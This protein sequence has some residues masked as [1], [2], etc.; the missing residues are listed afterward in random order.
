MVLCETK[1]HEICTLRNG[2]LYFAKWKSVLNKIKICTLRN[3]PQSRPWHMFFIFV[4]AWY[5]EFLVSL[6]HSLF[7]ANCFGKIRVEH[8]AFFTT[9]FSFWCVLLRGDFLYLH[10]T[11]KTQS[12]W[13]VSIAWWMCTKKECVSL[14]HSYLVLHVP[15]HAAKYQTSGEEF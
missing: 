12:F 3:E 10:A 2:N 6:K 1:R 14:I 5:G 11:I 4:A 9:S 7:A 15:H 8:C 13:W